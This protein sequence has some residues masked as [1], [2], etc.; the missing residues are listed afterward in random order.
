MRGLSEYVKVALLGTQR[1]PVPDLPPNSPVGHL[2]AQLEPATL[3]DKL[4]SL[5]GAITM[6]QHVGQLPDRLSPI[7]VEQ[8]LPATDL[9]CCSLSAARHLA[10]ILEGRYQDLLSEFLM[11]LSKTGQRVPEEYLPN[12]LERGTKVS[13]LRPLILPVL[14]QTGRWLAA[15]N[16]AWAYAAPEVDSWTGMLNQWRTGSP[17]ARQNLLR[18]VRHFNPERGRQLLESIWRAEA[19]AT[20]ALLIKELEIGLSMADEPFL[21]VALDDRH[22]IVR[23]KAAELLAYLPE[24]RLCQRMKVYLAPILTW[25]PDQAQQMTVTAPQHI[26]PA[27]VR[28]GVGLPNFKDIA[29]VRSAQIVDM[30]GAVPLSHWTE[31]WQS[32]P[33]A[34]LQATVTSRWPQTLLRGFTLAAERQRQAVWAET[35]LTHDQYGVSTVR[36]LAS[37]PV[38]R[39]ECLVGQVSQRGELLHKDS[40]LF[41]VLSRRAQPWTEAIAHIWLKHLADYLQQDTAS[42]TPEATLRAKFRQFARQCPPQMSKVIGETLLPLT[43]NGSAW[44]PPLQ[45]LLILLKFRQ[46]MLAALKGNNK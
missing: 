17:T 8:N 2:L 41:K 21:E 30:L 7:P 18:Q 40:L 3:E 29:R 33:E 10:Q 43:A 9:P 42:A 31:T 14:G 27:M 6:Y 11:A 26:S 34:I 4:L 36:L 32:S 12:L 25:T 46:G 35:L 19:D 23:R 37:L 5:A 20:R 1:E 28:D 44:H 24:S 22:L 39:F 45:E 16:P 38:E 15:Q 13:T